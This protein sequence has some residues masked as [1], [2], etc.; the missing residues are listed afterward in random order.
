MSTYEWT[1]EQTAAIEIRDKTVLV[2]AAAG[3]GK[4][5]TLTERIIQHIT[6][7][8]HPADISRMLIVTFTRAAAAELRS[9]IFAS[10]GVA[11]AKEPSSTHLASQLMKIGSAHISTIDS[12]YFE[13][14]QSNLSLLG[15]PSSLRIADDAE[16]AILAH[17]IMDKV[18]NE[19]YE[20]DPEFYS[21]VECFAGTRQLN[22]LS[23]IFLDMHQKLSSIPE[24]IEF[25]K[26]FADR[27]SVAA[28]E[29][30]F[31]TSYGE[32]LKNSTKD[33]AEHFLPLLSSA[34]AFIA[35]DP[36]VCAK[37]G[38]SFTYDL[39]VC[40]RLYNELVGEGAEYVRVK[41]I[42]DSY[43]PIG[44]KSLNK[45]F[46]SEELDRFK[47]H[48]TE[49]IKKLRD[50]A[51][52]S[53]SKSPETIN[54]A[55]ARTVKQIYTL[56]RLLEDF[57]RVVGEEKNRLGILTFNDVRRYTLRLLV[58][59][60]EQPTPLARQYA[61][62]FD[63]IYIDEYQDVDRVQ[64]LIFR[65]ISKPNNRFMVGDIKQSIYQFRGAE[66]Q[67]FAKYKTDFPEYDSAAASASDCASIFMSSNFRCDQSVIDFSNL[68]CSRIF[69][70]ISESIG[71]THDDDLKYAKKTAPEY[72]APAV[73]VDII[74]TPSRSRRLDTTDSDIDDLASNK[75]IEAE[76]IA[77][78]IDGLL[79]SGATK[80]DGKKLVPGDIAVLFRSS[81]I[82]PY[83]AEALRKRGIP[84]SQ[85]DAKKYFENP[86]VLMMLCI[87][88]AVDNPER[89]HVLAGALCSPIFDFSMDELVTLRLA[90][91]E[92]YSLYASL[93]QYAS[94]QKNDL[95]KKC[96]SFIS[97]LERWQDDAASLPVDRFMRMLFDDERFIASGIVSQ[98]SDSGEGGSILILYEYARK[99]ESG[100]FK[101]L[102]QF[103]EYVTSMIEKDKTFSIG[104]SI[105][106]PDKVSLMTIHKSKGLEFPVCFLCDTCHSIRS[107]DA[108]DSF[109]FDYPSGVAMKISDESGLARINTPMREAIVSKISTKQAE[110][111]MRILYVALTRAKERLYV[112]AATSKDIDRMLS[113]ATT[114]SMSFDR[115]TAISSCSSYIEWILV[116]CTT[117]DSCYK[118]NVV[119]YYDLFVAPEETDD[120]PEPEDLTYEPN[121]ELT[122]A[123]KKK[124]KFTYS[125]NKLTH[126]PSKISVSRLHPGVLDENDD[127]LELF[128]NEKKAKVPD[129]FLG[130]KP[131]EA[132]A[133]ERGTATHLF[134]QFCNFE[135]AVKNGVEQELASLELKKF[136]PANVASLVYVDEL[137]RFLSSE[138]IKRILSA[139]RIIR[140]QRFNI[141]FPSEAFVNKDGELLKQLEGESLAVQG[142]IDL[143]L[144]DENGDVELY[145]YK[146]DRL[147]KKAL[148]SDAEATKHMTE[149]HGQQLFYYSKAIEL[150]MGKKCKRVAVYS[151]HAA[152]LY[153][154]DLTSFA[155]TL[156]SIDQ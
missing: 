3:S 92:S 127:T 155:P 123:L 109:V 106:S 82:A 38:E 156:P 150:L 51:A 43:A 79:R 11:L 8:S 60:N 134:M 137:R 154:I 71:Y 77:E 9:R 52:K 21:F 47:E 110:E 87:L 89:D 53:Y 140:E 14:I 147:S 66:P 98:P 83:L 57:D 27:T 145:D 132:T 153:D 15:L 133:A 84:S 111:E 94:E 148:N 100:S 88:N 74:K 17:R 90:Y 120:T 136:I 93:C 31:C 45:K 95:A 30:F 67:L 13:L 114:R 126:V 33:L 55:L 152:K 63:E 131:T 108:G 78:K 5:A 104:E 81:T 86:E 102:Y 122:A 42:L 37:Y 35:S 105:Q 62:Q 54:A 80:A 139:K 72:I 7:T 73:N 101:G 12:F 22:M 1:K 138:L 116:G 44:L 99:F 64:D 20:A 25:L 151:T 6:D 68:V 103:L 69:E 113:T 39:D 19:T 129:F 91:G 26:D 34:N 65:S 115:Y 61:E 10:L 97:V 70:A 59:S 135:N 46:A 56:Y 18:I 4:T 41:N 128:S 146:T 29:D 96:E 125:Y 2:S 107:K 28:E 23:G 32:I 117:A 142:V 36:D 119:S 143:I 141:E 85:S 16:Y 49:F 149:A 130:D 124:L 24:G 75:Q 76:Y 58:D 144:I 40:R 112:T 48:R 121:P 118:L 50:L